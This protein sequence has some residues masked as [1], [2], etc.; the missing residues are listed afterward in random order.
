[1]SGLGFGAVALFVFFA[2]AAGAKVVAAYF[3]SGDAGA[4]AV[5]CG[6]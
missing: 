6:A 3:F 1:M 2:G 4:A 5:A